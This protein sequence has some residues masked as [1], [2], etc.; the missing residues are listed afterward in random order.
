MYGFRAP[1]VAVAL[2]QCRQLRDCQSFE[3]AR[4]S[5]CPHLPERYVVPF[6]DEEK[7]CSKRTISHDKFNGL[8]AVT[9][10]QGKRGGTIGWWCLCKGHKLGRA[11]GGQGIK[12]VSKDVL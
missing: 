7:R 9:G 10:H 4:R 1:C 12:H 2:E 5:R 11:R 8:A 6:D 3:N